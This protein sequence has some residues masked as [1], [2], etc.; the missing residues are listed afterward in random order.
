MTRLALVALALATQSDG[1]QPRYAAERGKKDKVYAEHKIGIKIEGSEQMTNFVRSMHPFL[2]MEKLVI[3]AE[4]T[5]Q[6]IARNRVKVE[7]DEA[8]IEC[9]YDDD[10][11]EMDFERGVPPPEGLD[12]DKLRQMMYFLAAAGKSYTLTPEGSYT[13]D[14]ANQDHNGEAMDL[15]SLA[16]TRMPDRPVKE[17][18]TYEKSW[19]GSRSE[20]NKTAKFNFTQKVKVEKIEEREGRKVAT[21]AAE[22]SGKLDQPSAEK[23][24]SADEQ[25]TKAEGKTRLVLEVETGRVLSAEGQG[26]VVGYFKGTAENGAKQDLTL[27]FSVEGKL[28]VQ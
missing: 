13:G 18:E 1:V 4:G 17:G 25:W 27:T 5:R 10:D 11:H 15:V 6:N 12:K 16:I 24:K 3:R 28:S 22:L 14:D 26:R 19:K 8:R 9:R 23:D 2:S 20:K 7:Y 21:L